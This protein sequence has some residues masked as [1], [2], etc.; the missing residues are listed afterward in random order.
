[1][2]NKK[3]FELVSRAKFCPIGVSSNCRMLPATFTK[4][5]LHHQNSAANAKI[6]EGAS[7]IHATACKGCLVASYVKEGIDPIL[8]VDDLEWITL[9]ELA[10][11]TNAV[12]RNVSTLGMPLKEIKKPSKASVNYKN[13]KLRERLIQQMEGKLETI[14]SLLV[15]V[16][17]LVSS[18]EKELSEISDIKF[19]TVT[20][21]IVADTVVEES[22]EIKKEIDYALISKYTSMKED[23]FNLAGILYDASISGSSIKKIAEESG[24]SVKY[25]R[26]LIN[27]YKSILEYV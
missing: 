1:M 7:T 22:N 26:S 20:T 5:C 25:V 9:Q 14:K 16:S 6:Y 3:E 12:K 24:K 11:I 2:K 17:D 8:I 18:I 4:L 27:K 19:T 13:K 21:P 23:T 10:V 15:R